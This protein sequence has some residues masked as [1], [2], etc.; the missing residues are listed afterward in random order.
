M[1]PGIPTAVTAAAILGC[2]N[3]CGGSAD[4]EAIRTATLQAPPTDAVERFLDAAAEHGG[5]AARCVE[6]LSDG[7]AKRVL[8]DPTCQ[9]PQTCATEG[10]VQAQGDRPAA[11]MVAT[12]GGKGQDP[13]FTDPL[14]PLLAIS[15]PVHYGVV[16]SALLGIDDPDLTEDLREPLA[17]AL[18]LEDPPA[19]PTPRCIVAGAD[20]QLLETLAEPLRACNEDVAHRFVVDPEG[21]VRATAP[22][23]GCIAEALVATALSVGAWRVVDLTCV[24][25]AL[26]VDGPPVAGRRRSGGG[27]GGGGA[28]PIAHLPDEHQQALGLYARQFRY[29]YE[30]QLKQDPELGGQIVL[31]FTLQPDGSVGDVATTGSLARAL[32]PCVTRTAKEMDFPSIDA[33]APV[34]LP[35]R[36][37]PQA[38][39]F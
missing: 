15:D 39:P 19:E 35:L 18:A 23:E 25:S 1:R 13:L 12:C 20:E 9:C 6:C 8:E 22:G 16:H 17:M 10:Y 27:G 31:S 21:A 14:L 2:C 3:P 5:F 11:R 24:A 33:A 29:C 36:F 38:R 28:N 30:Q 37:Q 26:P 34:R 7:D 4:V 32:G